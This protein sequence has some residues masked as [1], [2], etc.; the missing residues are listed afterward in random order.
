AARRRYAMRGPSRSFRARCEGRGLDPR[1]RLARLDH[2]HPRF[3]IKRRPN[4]RDA[5]GAANATV[6]M[7]R[8]EKLSADDMSR[9]LISAHAHGRLDNYITKRMPPMIIYLNAG[10]QLQTHMGGQ[11]RGSRRKSRNASIWSV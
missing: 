10:G 8:G 3:A 1:E 7:V 9:L 2:R 4:E 11:R 6:V 5:R